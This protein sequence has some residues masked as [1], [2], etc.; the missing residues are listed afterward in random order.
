MSL[1]ATPP[2]LPTRIANQNWPAL[3]V[4]LDARGCAILPGLLTRD[5]CEAMA[6]LYDGGAAFRNRDLG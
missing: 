1:A 2:S 3:E 4:E 5:E 6:A